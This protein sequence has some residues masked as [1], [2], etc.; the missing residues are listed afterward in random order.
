MATMV[1]AGSTGL[2]SPR[3]C[4][5]ERCD[6]SQ[7]RLGTCAGR[8]AGV[9][10]AC[11]CVCVCLSVCSPV[12]ACRQCEHVPL[13]FCSGIQRALVVEKNLANSRYISHFGLKTWSFG[14]ISVTFKDAPSTFSFPFSAS[15]ATLPSAPAHPC[16]ILL[17]TLL[18]SKRLC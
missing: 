6:G 18:F 15:R 17:V 9:V 3:A 4:H 7:A 11:V 14:A 16:A 12:C 2:E 8:R 5:G 13:L 10:N 1:G